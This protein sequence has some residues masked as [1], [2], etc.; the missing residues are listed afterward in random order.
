MMT[1]RQAARALIADCIACQEALEIGVHGSYEGYH[2]QIGAMVNNNA[3]DRHSITVRAANGVSHVFNV[4]VI[5]Y[6]IEAAQR[7]AM[8]PRQAARALVTESVRR[9]V[10]KG[11]GIAKITDDLQEVHLGH[12]WAD[13][14]AQ[15]GPGYRGG[16]KGGVQRTTRPGDLI[17]RD[18]Q[19]V[20]RNE[21]FGLRDVVIELYVEM[22]Q[23]GAQLSLWGRHDV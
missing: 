3:Y 17:V 2:L 15:I 4:P 10:A 1:P 16:S 6:E 21:I 11:Y 7:P 19:G 12:C 20:V 13:Y 9:R 14:W 8:T 22:T 5:R 23:Q 18:V